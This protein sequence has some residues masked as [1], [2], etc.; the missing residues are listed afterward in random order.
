MAEMQQTITKTT[1]TERDWQVSIEFR[2]SERIFEEQLLELIE[3]YDE[4]GA[5]AALDP[6]ELGGS[7]TLTLSAST[8]LEALTELY[9]LQGRSEVLEHA[10]ITGL[11]IVDW[12][13]A[14]QRNREPLYPQVV[15]YAEIA[16]LAHVS[17]QRAAQFV[18]IESFPKPVIQTSQGKL[19]SRDA[20]VA[21]VHT[22]NTHAGRPKAKQ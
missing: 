20:V 7:V 1:A 13:T 2:N 21:W 5:S 16:Q 15:G 9:V 17:R 8:P 11:E 22:R 6:D 18:K 10:E 3:E 12:K 4:F 14:Q 19:Y